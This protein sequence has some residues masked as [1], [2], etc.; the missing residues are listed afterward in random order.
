MAPAAILL[1]I[2]L[3]CFA[4]KRVEFSSSNLPIILIDTGGRPIINERKI[5]AEMRVIDRGLGK[6]NSVTDTVYAFRG[7]IG[8]ELRGSSTQSFPKKQFAV[9][10]RDSNGAN[11]NVPLLGLP[12][13]ND[14]VLYGPYSDKSLMR[15]V[16]AYQIARDLG[17]YASRSRY[18]ELVLN[19]RYW[20]VYVLL[21]KIK[22]DRNRVDIAK[23]DSTDLAPPDIT[24]GYIIKVDK[25]AGENLGG[26]QSTMP[27][28]YPG[29]TSPL[30]FYQFHYPKPDEILPQQAA[31]IQK[32]ITDFENMMSSPF[33]DDP[34]NGMWTAL[35]IGS[36]IDYVIVNEISKN[37]DGYRLSA[38][39]YKDRDDSDP[40]LHLGPVWDFNLAFGNADYYDAAFP[41]GWQ[42]E[43]FLY[44][45]RFN[46][47]GDAYMI[48][49]WWGR[50]W[51][52]ARFQKKLWERWW[53][54]R[55]GPLDIDRLLDFIDRT[56]AELDE[57]Q[58]RNFRCWPILG[59]YVWPNA[60]IGAS[61]A[62]EVKYLKNWLQDR[63]EWMDDHLKYDPAA[64]REREERVNS[65]YLGAN[66]PN[67]FNGCTV[68][69]LVLNDPQWLN[70]YIYD[71]RGRVVATLYQGLIQAG[72]E[73]FSW[74]GLTD[75]GE[76]A[77]SGMYFVCAEGKE[78][79]TLKMLLL[80]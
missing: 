26:W 14:W 62:D 19:G 31:Y 53:E 42:I 57:A 41:E 2:A 54:L 78:I 39:M 21:E 66:Y 1:F 74:D 37:V 10:T 71:A 32:F 40:R 28:F 70:V 44:N 25:P 29:G 68:I 43:Y 35:D 67:P 16:F 47:G 65:I 59:T 49:A 38:F 5:D 36:V 12:P 9:E 76:P 18:C 61:F 24:G 4:Q 69:P 73:L 77:P 80:R 51:T 58:Q 50:I 22:R 75:I 7:R 33:Y 30:P 48:P 8:I 63:V 27:L 72:K 11:L 13:E 79:Q 23:L 46:R 60:Y 6:R 3:P 52:S 55:R 20:G 45:E 56:A 64:V 17:R 15:N 34:A